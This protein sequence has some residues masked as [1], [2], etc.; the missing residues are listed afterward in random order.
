MRVNLM[1]C[2]L[3]EQAKML[4]STTDT[5][6]SRYQIVITHTSATLSFFGVIDGVRGLTKELKM[7]F[8]FHANALRKVGQSSAVRA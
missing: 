7:N 8:E 3:V 2:V 6:C 4:V 1:N 5:F